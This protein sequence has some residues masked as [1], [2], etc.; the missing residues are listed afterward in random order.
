MH[1][2][3]EVSGGNVDRNGVIVLNNKIMCFA[4]VNILVI[5]YVETTPVE[6]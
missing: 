5:T 3:T 6:G 1:V 4:T 2:G